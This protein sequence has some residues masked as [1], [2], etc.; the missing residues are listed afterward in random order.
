MLEGNWK[1]AIFALVLIAL[2]ALGGLVTQAASVDPIVMPGNPDCADLGYDMELKVEPVASGTYTD[3]VLI[4]ELEVYDPY[5]DWES[6]IGVSAVIVKGGPNA[7]VYVY[8]PAA[9]EDE[10]LIAPINPNTGKP[11]GL[12]HISF[13]YVP[14]EEELTV[15]KTVETSFVREH[16]WNIDKSIRTDNGHLLCTVH[17]LIHLY[18]DGSGDEYAYWT[19]DLEYKDYINRDLKIW[20][21]ITIVNTGPS[22]A[23]ITGV[24]DMLN[25]ITAT[26]NCPVE[27]PSTLPMGE[28]L[29]CTYK[30]YVDTMIEGYNVVT[31]T[32]ER[33]V[34]TGKAPIIWGEP[35][36]ELYKTVNVMDEAFLRFPDVKYR[37]FGPVTAESKQ[38]TYKEWVSYEEFSGLCGEGAPENQH[39]WWH[40]RAWIVET[41]QEA[42]A[43]LVLHIDCP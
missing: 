32:T 15:T 20:G 3:G 16:E 36:E 40:N 26:V 7:N 5:F 6:N 31:V 18:E 11:Y 19:I 33:D 39:W 24:D 34:Y 41:G 8:D 38:F 22:D 43:S 25:G 35:A 23:V 1:R 9:T 4:V 17:A 14:V 28:T 37:E 10:G 42:Y 29:V 12:S 13:C 21:D 30:A 2:L 27:F